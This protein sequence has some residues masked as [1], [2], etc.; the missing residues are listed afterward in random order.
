MKCDLNLK[1][2]EN[3]NAILTVTRG[4]FYKDLAFTNEENNELKDILRRVMERDSLT[5]K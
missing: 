1:L 3:E 5:Y 2:D 4:N